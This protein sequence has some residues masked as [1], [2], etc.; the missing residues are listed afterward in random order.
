MLDGVSLDQLRT[1]IMAVDEGS[2]SAA[3]RKLN[4][5]QSAVS[6][7]VSGLEEQIG[8]AL[9]DRSGRYPTLTPEGVLLL[10]DARNVVSGV[11]T[12]KARARLMTSGVEAELSVVIDVFFP[13][14]V[15]SAAAKE[16]AK[17]FPLTPLRLFVEA[18]GAA[19]QPVMDGRCSL[20]I[21][22]PLPRPFPSLVSERLGELPL[23][24]VASPSHPLAAFGARIPRDELAKHVQLVLTDRSDLTSGR[25][26]GVASPSTWRLADLST[27][28]AFLKECVGW[29]G[30]PLHMIKKDVA[31]GTLVV[32]DVDDMPLSGFILTMSAFHRPSQPPGPA[33]RW[34]VDQVKSLWHGADVIVSSVRT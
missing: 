14:A 19:Y 1:F 23:V 11:D 30:M 4:R 20:G 12:L 9:F 17:Q 26:F 7:W 15:V 5:V 32:L 3:A 28:H 6:G 16:F 2:F 8:V 13:T 21:L 10:A 33:G 31:E 34:F 29:G 27:K 25:D 24:A 22:P 18:L